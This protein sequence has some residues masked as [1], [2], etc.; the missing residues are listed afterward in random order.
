MQHKLSPNA[1]V[2]QHY[3]VSSQHYALEFRDL[4]T[5]IVKALFKRQTQAD[6]KKNNSPTGWI[7]TRLFLLFY[8]PSFSSFHNA[9]NVSL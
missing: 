1:A 4:E 7:H 9:H 2:L 3:C 5:L 8:I 6:K